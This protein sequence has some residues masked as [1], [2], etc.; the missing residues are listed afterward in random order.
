[1]TG[2]PRH[3]GASERTDADPSH[4]LAEL[5]IAAAGIGTFDW[6]LDR[7]ILSWDDQLLALWGYDRDGFDRTI[8]GFNARV[9][10]GDLPRVAHAL[11]AAIASCGEYEAEFRVVLPD[12]TMRWV[13]ARGRALDDGTGRPRRML[14]AAYDTTARRESQGRVARVLEAMPTAFYS[15]SRDWT[16]TYVNAEA[17]RLLGRTR[18]ELVGHHIW[19]LFPAGR[20]DSFEAPYRT[21][22][23]SGRP[24]AFDA[25]YP[26]P[27]EGWYELHAWPGPDGLAVYFLDITSWRRAQLEAEQAAGRADLMAR[28]TTALTETLQGDEAVARL[29]RLVVPDLADWCIV[30]LV[31]DDELAGTRRGLRD[32]GWW[33]ADPDQAPLLERYAS[34]RMEALRSASYLSRSLETGRPLSVETDAAQRVAEVLVPGLARDALLEL[35]PEAMAILPLRGRGGPVGLVTLA[36]AAGRGP[37]DLVTAQELAGRAG[38]A[39]DNSRLYR[40]QRRLAEG[41]QRSMLTAPPEPDHVEIVVRY[42]PAA[43][44]A[45]VGGD[46]YDA[47]LQPD[48]ATVLVIGDVVGHDIAAA[49]AMGQVRSLLRGIAVATG[50]GPAR[51]L[52]EVDQAMRTLQTDTIATAVVAR[53]E[54]STD[55]QARGVTHVRWANAG[56]PP[57]MVVNPDGSV[58]VLT[59]IRPDPLLGVLPDAPRHES[60]VALDRGATVLLYTDGL[61]ER[62]DRSLV[63]GMEALR[64]LLVELAG[65]DLQDLC[66]A[67][68]AR[69]LPDRPEDDVALVAVRLHRQDRPRPAEA[70]PNRV[71]PGV[72]PEVSA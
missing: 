30:T 14:G 11:Q 69:L 67:I 57:P 47:F 6:D 48:G 70:G 59:G 45:Q 50:L 37:V 52:S 9:H 13:A 41:L 46:W 17:E 62:R 56:H 26:A 39:L 5:A 65:L 40:Q 15:L 64:D 55:E 7:G 66:D 1:V 58:A 72:P 54:Q 36:R 23:E 68:L 43:Q 29:A 2:D 12:G 71:P 31:D 34:L 51:L 3:D 49:A 60:E 61:I 27:L 4:V 63:E 42:E 33:H 24:V 16:F 35:A 21:A 38:L 44:A 25:Y 8:A 53:I 10:P 32:A 22:M 18:D 19:D 28:V 20:G